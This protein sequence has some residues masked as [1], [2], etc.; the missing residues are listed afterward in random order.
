MYMYMQVFLERTGLIQ[1]AVLHIVIGMVAY[2]VYMQAYVHC[3]CLTIA[4]F[5]L[6]YYKRVAHYPLLVY[7][8]PLILSYHSFLLTDP[9]KCPFLA[10]LHNKSM[11]TSLNTPGTT[12]SNLLLTCTCQCNHTCICAYE[13]CIHEIQMLGYLDLLELNTVW[14]GMT[15]CTITHLSYPCARWTHKC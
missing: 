1:L 15:A 9:L 10:S 12:T 5:Y 7:R 3:K 6:K 13:Q 2:N 8:H 4:V 14:N 11:G